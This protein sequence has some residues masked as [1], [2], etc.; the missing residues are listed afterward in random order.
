MMM[1]IGHLRPSASMVSAGARPG[2]GAT[3]RSGPEKATELTTPSE[4]SVRRAAGTRPNRRS[5]RPVMSTSCPPLPGVR[6]WSR[7]DDGEDDG[8]DDGKD[9]GKD[10][11]EDN[12]EDQR[13]T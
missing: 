9:D 13:R 4:R 8:E 1:G 11:S 12:G 2:G 10:N 7:K 3:V 6:A 5:R